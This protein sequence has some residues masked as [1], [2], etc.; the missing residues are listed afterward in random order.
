MSN[1]SYQL[2][3]QQALAYQALI[4][5]GV[6]TDPGSG[7]ISLEDNSVYNIQENADQI[8]PLLNT[9][10][11]NFVNCTN[12]FSTLFPIFNIFYGPS[13]IFG[14]IVGG[15]ATAVNIGQWM[16]ALKGYGGYDLC[17]LNFKANKNSIYAALLGL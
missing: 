11:A 9:V 10:T 12:T 14:L 2:T 16:A 13:L 1:Y 17:F 7:G 4:S 15:S 3:T 5:N 8:V 6:G